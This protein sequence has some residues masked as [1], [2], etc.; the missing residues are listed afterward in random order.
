MFLKVCAPEDGQR[1]DHVLAAHFPDHS[2]ARLQKFIRSGFCRLDNEKVLSPATRL[3]VGMVLDFEV[4]E[5]NNALKPEAGEICVLYEDKDIAIINKS[6]D[7]TV[8]PSPSCPEHTLAQ[9]LLARFPRLQEQAG[10][11][12]GIVHRLDK[13]TSGLMI[14]ALSEKARLCLIADFAERLIKKEYL[15]LVAGCPPDEGQCELPIGRHPALKTRMAVVGINHGGKTARTSWRKL[16]QAPDNDCALL[17]VQIHTGRTHQIRVHLAAS[18]HPILGDKVYAPEQVRNMAP[19]QMLHSCLLGFTHPISGDRLEFYSPPPEDFSNCILQRATQMQR[20]VVTGNQGCGKSTFCKMLAREGMP[21]IS[22][23]EI[24][25]RLYANSQAIVDWLRLRNLT[26]VIA[27]K[28]GINKDRLLALMQTDQNLRGEFE[29]FVHA[30]V[31]DEIEA[32]WKQ[33]QIKGTSCALAEIP[34]YFESGAQAHIK[35]APLVIGVSCPKASRWQ[36]IMQNRGW[37]REKVEAIENWQMPEPKKMS[38]CDIVIDNDGTTD[39]LADKA[40][41]L[42]L[43]LQQKAPSKTVPAQLKDIINSCQS[44]LP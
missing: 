34:L 30:M 36:R 10:D 27:D 35:P 11:R 18:G 37:T 21:K 6:A 9:R 44:G 20:I 1:L 16:W 3:R 31:F 28:G 13:D 40:A 24:V 43:K 29:K 26:E 12:P 38:L 4:P 7:L 41:K 15:A 2:R 33:E 42:F 22:A 8:H 32:F 14:I 25:A 17:R 23:D 39:E 19:R 5:T